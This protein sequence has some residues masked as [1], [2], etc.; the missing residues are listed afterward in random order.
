MIISLLLIIL[1]VRK[2]LLK[3]SNLPHFFLL[4]VIASIP[5]GTYN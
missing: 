3:E 1:G 5:E 4:Q 2:G